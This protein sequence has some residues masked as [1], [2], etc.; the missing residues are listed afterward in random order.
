ME[1]DNDPEERRVYSIVGGFYEVYKEL[2]HGLLEHLYVLALDRELTSRGHHAQREA[3]VLVYYKGEPLGWQRIDL[4]VDECIVVEVKSTRELHPSATRQTYNYLHAARLEN[5][6]LL[7]FGLEPRW[8]RVIGR[9][10]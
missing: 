3:P 7:H 9:G 1:R 10:D 2:S 8:Y 6:L 4:L 5:G